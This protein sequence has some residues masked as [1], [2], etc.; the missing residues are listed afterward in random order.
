MAVAPAVADAWENGSATI[1]IRHLPLER[2]H[3]QAREAAKAVVCA[4]WQGR[5]RE[6]H[7]ALL[8]D[9]SWIS[10][11]DWIGLGEAIGVGDLARFADCLKSR[12]AE[13][14]VDGDMRLAA[15]LGISSTPT[16]VTVHGVYHGANGFRAALQGIAGSMR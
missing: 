9:R 14:R 13:S 7:D 10:R 4:E 12:K 8:A 3:P 1:V 15:D 6:A 11:Q 2:I 16:F 5:L